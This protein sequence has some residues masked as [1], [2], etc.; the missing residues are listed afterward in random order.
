[1]K[2]ARRIMACALAVAVAIS[3]FAVAPMNTEAAAPKQ[4]TYVLDSKKGVCYPTKARVGLMQK[5]DT[6]DVYLVNEGDYIASVKSSST[7]LV[8]KLT[9]KAVY[10]G[11][12]Y[13]MGT[14]SD[15]T[16]VKCKANY[17]IT[18]FAKK[19]GTYTLTVTVKNAKKKTTCKKKIKVYAE[20][21]S[22][23]INTFK[24]AG[25]LCSSYTLTN[26]KSGKINVKLNKGFKLQKIEV[27]TYAAAK[28][29]EYSPE[30]VFKKVK[31]NSKI[32]LATSTK[33]ASDVYEYSYDDG[34]Y[35]YESGYDVEYLCPIT[36]IRI[37][38][39]DTKLGTV[40]TTEYELFYQN[41]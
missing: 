2:L 26:K 39:K 16:N 32:S 35:S 1:M 34:D 27:G 12:Q 38:Y 19:K 9:R 14:L 18:C 13:T 7:N 30:P 11:S 31:N 41:K 22:A 37:T 20:E 21:Y 23:P 10:T 5:F 25:K 24:Y 40:Q 3:T 36:I 33:Y 29:K 4:N 17:D 28:T 15:G 8:A 6:V